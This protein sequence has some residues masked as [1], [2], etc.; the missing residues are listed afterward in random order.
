MEKLD[1]LVEEETSLPNLGSGS[2]IKLQKI[3]RWIIGITSKT[4]QLK[5]VW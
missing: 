3:T 5:E 4:L 2:E 1:R